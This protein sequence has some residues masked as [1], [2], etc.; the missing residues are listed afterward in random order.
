MLLAHETAGLDVEYANAH[1]DAGAIGI[2]LAHVHEFA[3][4]R[5]PVDDPAA[6]RR[7]SRDTGTGPGFWFRLMTRWRTGDP[8]AALARIRQMTGWDAEA[9]GGVRFD[10]GVRVRLRN[11]VENDRS[12]G[13]MG[14]CAGEQE[15]DECRDVRAGGFQRPSSEMVGPNVVFVAMSSVGAHVQ[16]GLIETMRA[17]EGRLPWLGRHLER[18]RASVAALGAAAPPDGLSDLIRFA[19][20]GGSRDRVVRVQVTDGHA[21]IATRDVS[22]EQAISVIVSRE[23][24]RPY[25]YK[26]TERDQFGRAL[27]GARRRG[28]RDALLVTAEGFAAEGTTWNL[29]WWDKGTLCTPAASLGIL[30]GVGRQRIMELAAVEER[31]A[32]VAELVGRSLFVVNAVRG[33]VQVETF[34]GTPVPRDPRTAELAAAFWP[35]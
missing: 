6:G 26:T 27:A 19:A 23:V 16:V 15:A 32:R 5:G 17:R 4:V 24:H 7:Y 33:V 18:L 3:V 29:L 13:C 28:A 21:E 12:G 10:P 1:H 11:G 34:E 9:R 31:Q 22:A 30:P 35:D 8:D 2:H 14:A 25:P 20:G